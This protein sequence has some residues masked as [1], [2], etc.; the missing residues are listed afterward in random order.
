M[1]TRNAQSAVNNDPKL[2]GKYWIIQGV[3]KLT[4]LRVQDDTTFSSWA[5]AI[6]EAEKRAR[7]TPGAVFYVLEAMEAITV[8][9]PIVRTQ[10]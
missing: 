3:S 5:L 8:D 4:G 7:L 9:T 6:K 10:L 2:P 1:N